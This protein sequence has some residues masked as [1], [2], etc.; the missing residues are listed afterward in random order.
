M[1]L[2]II[3]AAFVILGMLTFAEPGAD[4]QGRGKRTNARDPRAIRDEIKMRQ[5]HTA[6]AAARNSQHRSLAVKVMLMS[7]TDLRLTGSAFHVMS[8]RLAEAMDN[9]IINGE[10][11]KALGGSGI[12]PAFRRAIGSYLMQGYRGHYLD[13]QRT[14]AYKYERASKRRHPIGHPIDHAK[15]TAQPD[16][17]GSK[18]ITDHLNCVLSRARKGQIGQSEQIYWANQFRDVSIQMSQMDIAEK[19]SIGMKKIASF[20]QQAPCKP[21][22]ENKPARTDP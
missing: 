12:H 17:C 18:A 19:Q 2:K 1:V 13:T 9:A 22:P 5:A 21:A 6:G 11:L 16:E 8:K 15:C 20:V 7:H 10:D 4:A 3:A 14:E